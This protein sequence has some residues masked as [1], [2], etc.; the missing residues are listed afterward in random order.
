MS[1][2][3][4]ARRTINLNAARTS[5]MYSTHPWRDNMALS[6]LVVVWMCKTSSIGYLSEIV[7]CNLS[8]QLRARFLHS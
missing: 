4:Y 6:I 7:Y 3:I 8:L 2:N 5:G 1:R